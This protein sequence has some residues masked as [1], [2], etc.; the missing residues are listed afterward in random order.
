LNDNQHIQQA[1]YE[2]NEKTLSDLYYF[3]QDQMADSEKQQT[4]TEPY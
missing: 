3:L 1:R 4:A 2:V